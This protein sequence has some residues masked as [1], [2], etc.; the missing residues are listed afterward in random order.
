MQRNTLVSLV[1][2]AALAVAVP[3][4]APA[5]AQSAVYY[6]DVTVDAV[7]GFGIGVAVDEW[8]NERR[9]DGTVDHLIILAKYGRIPAELPMALE[10]AR[11]LV[12]Q[13]AV[14]VTSLEEPVVVGLFLDG[15]IPAQEEA[16]LLHLEQANAE[17]A[18]RARDE[19]YTYRGFGVAVYHGSWQGPLSNAWL[20]DGEVTETA[21]TCQDGGTGAR[22]CSTSCSGGSSCSVT[23]DS[24]Y[25]AC[26]NCGIFG[27]AECDC[28]LADGGGWGGGG[29]GGGGGDDCSGALGWC[30]PYCMRC[31]PIVY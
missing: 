25:W 3:G 26:C 29:G 16:R 27:G 15:A 11:V 20:V 18:G 4:S 24:G 9:V 2:L 10:G 31:G 13:Q 23:C 21:G 12:K 1:C 30:P 5:L 19:V 28:I 8:D 6:G 22:S 14:V 17:R 7:L